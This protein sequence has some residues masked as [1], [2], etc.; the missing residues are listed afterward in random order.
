[1]RV[2]VAEPVPGVANGADLPQRTSTVDLRDD[3]P[4]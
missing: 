1:V 3:A 2:D 4:R